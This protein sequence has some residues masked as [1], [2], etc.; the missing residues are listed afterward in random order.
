VFGNM[1]QIVIFCEHRAPRGAGGVIC[2]G[3]T[4]TCTNPNG[5]CSCVTT[6]GIRSINNDQLSMISERVYESSK[7]QRREIHLLP[8]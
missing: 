6:C 2:P 1:G 3:G 7:G 4:W 5:H 8:A